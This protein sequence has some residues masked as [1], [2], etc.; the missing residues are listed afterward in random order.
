MRERDEIASWRE[1][2]LE[3]RMEPKRQKEDGIWRVARRRW[4][5]KRKKK[6]RGT[7]TRMRMRMR[8][9]KCIKTRYRSQSDTKGRV[10]VA[11]F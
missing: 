8:D 3:P 6:K 1:K 9:S 2:S 10:H 5:G 7:R 4:R 11:L